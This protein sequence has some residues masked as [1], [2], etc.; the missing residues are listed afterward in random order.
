MRFRNERKNRLQSTQSGFLIQLIRNL[1]NDLAADKGR[2]DTQIIPMILT[3]GF[4]G[5]IIYGR[6]A[7]KRK[8]INDFT[9]IREI[10]SFQYPVNLIRL[11]NG[12]DFSKL[13][14]FPVP[15]PVWNFSEARE[16]NSIDGL[17]LHGWGAWPDPAS[18]NDV[19][20]LQKA[21]ELK[22]LLATV[23]KDMPVFS[24]SGNFELG[25][26]LKNN[27]NFYSIK[28]LSGKVWLILKTK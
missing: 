15:C 5:N 18:W 19:I 24:P 2:N 17:E 13:V 7:D 28:D 16:E 10:H 20:P 12:S 3:G 23:P 8:Q 27:V 14:Q 21:V 6:S 25:G 11:K 22:Q 1:T 4:S 9:K 26:R